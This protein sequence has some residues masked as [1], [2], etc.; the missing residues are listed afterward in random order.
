MGIKTLNANELKTKLDAGENILLID[1][2]ETAEWLPM[3][4][5]QGIRRGVALLEMRTEQQANTAPQLGDFPVSYLPS[6]QLA[7]S[8]RRLVR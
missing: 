5:H 4:D 6:P 1:C 3:S 7:H 8:F 2:R